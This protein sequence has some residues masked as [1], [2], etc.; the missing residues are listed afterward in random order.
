MNKKPTIHHFNERGR[1]VLS[2]Q[3]IEE[4]NKRL[5]AEN[6][7]LKRRLKGQ[8]LRAEFI[9]ESDAVPLPTIH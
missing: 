6:E 2:D 5:T 4:E 7:E 9:G 3:H 8:A 1:S